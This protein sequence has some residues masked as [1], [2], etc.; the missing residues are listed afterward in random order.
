MGTS[1]S[2]LYRQGLVSSATACGLLKSITKILRLRSARCMDGETRIRI[3]PLSI[4]ASISNAIV[5]RCGKEL[6]QAMPKILLRCARLLLHTR[7][8]SYRRHQLGQTCRRSLR[9]IEKQNDCHSTLVSNT[10]LITLFRSGRISYAVC[11]CSGT[12]EQYQR[13]T[14][15]QKA[16]AGGRRVKISRKW[17]CRLAFVALH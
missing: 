9:Y 14:T 15:A 7:R 13:A 8:P 10:M 12:F 11:M 6:V 1:L 16:I 5:I 3:N 17:A 4:S 2:D